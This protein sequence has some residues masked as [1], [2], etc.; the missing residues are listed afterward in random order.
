MQPDPSTQFLID[1]ERQFWDAIQRKDGAATARMTAPVAIITGAQGVSAINPELM[2]RLTVEGQWSIEAYEFDEGS[3]QATLIG[4]DTGVIGY[5]V[6]ESLIV[7]GQALTFKANDS[8]VW[9]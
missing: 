8:S 4:P 3:V 9:V 2:A 5:S 7:D 6:S 1:L